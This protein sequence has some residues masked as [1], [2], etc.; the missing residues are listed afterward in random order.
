MIYVIQQLIS[1]NRTLYQE[2][3]G[4]SNY[5]YDTKKANFSCNVRS[6][7]SSF[8]NMNINKN[9]LYE[10]FGDIK[11]KIGSTNLGITSVNILTSKENI[12]SNIGWIFLF[13][14]IIV[15]LLLYLLFFVQEDIICSK[16]KL[17]KF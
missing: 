5:N 12:T 13:S 3:C 11:N 6:R 8:E 4:F 10:N 14:F 1:G 15:C 17:M 9:K 16:I 2:G 7:S